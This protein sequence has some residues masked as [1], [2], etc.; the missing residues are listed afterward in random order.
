M[1]TETKLKRSLDILGFLVDNKQSGLVIFNEYLRIYKS[2]KNNYNSGFGKYSI[3]IND[4]QRRKY[5]NQE[6]YDLYINIERYLQ[7]LLYY[8][9]KVNYI[10]KHQLKPVIDYLET[11]IDEKDAKQVTKYTFNGYTEIYKAL[12]NKENLLSTKKN[13]DTVVMLLDRCKRMK[14]IPDMGNDSITMYDNVRGVLN[15]VY[16]DNIIQRDQRERD[17]RERDQ[18]ERDQRERDQREQKERDQREQKEREQ[19]EQ[20]EQKEREQREQKE[21]EQ[22]EQKQREREQREQKERE[23][24]EQ[25]QREQREQREQK[26]REQREQRE[27][28]EREQREQKER[29]QQERE[30]KEREQ[31]RE[32]KEQQ[33]REQKEREQEREQKEQQ[34][35]EQAREQ[36][37]QQEQQEREQQERDQQERE[38]KEQQEQQEREQQEREQKEQQEREREQKEQQE[39]EQKEQQEREQKEQQEREREQK[40][41]EQKEQK[42]SVSNRPEFALY[43]NIINRTVNNK[44]NASLEIKTGITALNNYISSFNE[45]VEFI[46]NIK[47][48][49]VNGEVNSKLIINPVYEFLK[50]KR[51]RINKYI[52]THNN[53]LSPKSSSE[54]ISPNILKTFDDKET[55]VNIRRPTFRPSSAYAT[56]NPGSVKLFQGS[57]TGGAKERVYNVTDVLKY[58]DHID[59]CIINITMILILIIMIMWILHILYKP[60]YNEQKRIKAH[61]ID[62]CINNNHYK[63]LTCDD[64]NTV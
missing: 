35:R 16:D 36:K 23:Q 62:N 17:Q 8:P 21:R 39:R 48:E 27:Q 31:E 37:E 49:R 43:E 18:R 45:Y 42:I 63:R 11:L 38:Q 7:N 33:E 54:K 34:E 10:V 58:V 30:Q 51:K 46:N 19:R 47:L 56:T 12:D 20:R 28:K 3:I 64:S 55:L 9:I 24:R 13:T 14:Y 41:R 61:Y 6:Y 52:N 40:E 57:T 2:I 25:K 50:Q 29:E 4:T 15:Q 5:L 1:Y 26:E 60:V 32:Q 59:T 53:R 44:Y 22:R